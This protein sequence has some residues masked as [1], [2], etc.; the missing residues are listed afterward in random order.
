MRSWSSFVEHVRC[1]LGIDV[2]SVVS[3]CDYGSGT[4]DRGGDGSGLG[5]GFFF[6]FFSI[7]CFSVR[8]IAI[9]PDDWVRA[10]RPPARKNRLAHTGESVL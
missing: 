5:L 2:R 4:G 9:F 10:G 7:F 8:A 6:F 1:A 3:M